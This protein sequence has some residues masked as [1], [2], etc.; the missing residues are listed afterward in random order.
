[1]KALTEAVKKMLDALAHD[2]AGEYLTRREKTRILAQQ[3][4]ANQAEETNPGLETQYATSTTRRVGLYLGS[5]LP[6]VVMDYV[7]QTCDR[8]QSELTVL[9]FESENTA[10]LLLKSH[11]DA[12][13]NSGVK[14]KLVTLSDEQPMV[15][16]SRY[17]RRHP[18]IAF[19]A[20]KDSGYLG[21]MIQKG[22]E[23]RNA[24]PVP[25][26]VVA[27]KEDSANQPGQPAQPKNFNPD[28]LVKM[29]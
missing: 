9:T 20:C 15:G 13:N 23:F 24:L 18:E 28:E 19:L 11:Q 8:L 1:M 5:E 4:K 27:T 12:L 3:S 10:R 16:L 14:M 21:H 17:L 22:D 7:I 26:V 25:V 6:P 2:H 29:C